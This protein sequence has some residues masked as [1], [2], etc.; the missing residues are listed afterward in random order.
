MRARL[1]DRKGSDE[2]D[3]V[4]THPAHQQ[5]L[6]ALIGL[7]RDLRACRTPEDLYAFQ[8]KLRD[9]VLEVEKH[10]N[11]IT[12]QIKRLHRHQKISTDAPEL[13]TD[14]DRNAE[15][16]WTFE[17]DVYER[18]WRQ[19]KTVADALAW[20][21]FHYDRAI[22]IA[23]SRAQA[24]GMMYGKTGLAK[25]LET[26]ETAWHDEHQFVLH[27]DLTNVIRVGDL[28]VFDHDGYAWLREIKTNE[29]RRVR[30]QDQLLA[31]T[32]QVLAEKTGALPSGHSPLHTGIDYRTN[33]GGLRQLLDLAHA[34]TGILGGKVSSGRA[35]VA[36]SQ[37][38]AANHFT[39]EQFAAQFDTEFARVRC[40][41]GADNPGHTLTLPSIDNAGHH[42]ADPPWAIYPISAETAA[43]LIADGMFFVVCMNPH[44]I[45]DALSKTGV[46]ARW[47][48]RLDGTENVDAPLLEVSKRAGNR[49]I[50]CSLNFAAIRG[51]ML[52]LIDLRTWSLQV[53]ATLSGDLQPNTQPWPCFARE[54]KTWI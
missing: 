12:Q 39:P 46:Q 17:A 54:A 52:E 23:L 40:R 44:T 30:A 19:L 8:N 4:L 10:R 49:R 15:T 28:T 22:I 3:A 51:L 53:A 45:I 27:H 41:I 7:I 6:N 20:K 31:A 48:Q 25:E 2:T 33:L 16:S 9:H 50:S 26:I 35:V 18:I 37:Y 13:G 42:R 1:M 11:A 29:N 32:S 47:L 43:S 36:V 38:T 14:R 21:A 34:R 24:P 5:T